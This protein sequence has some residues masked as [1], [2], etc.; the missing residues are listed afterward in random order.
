MM[1]LGNDI[2]VGQLPFVHTRCR[3]ISKMDLELTS[4]ARECLLRGPMTLRAA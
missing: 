3:E 1:V 4:S 2:A